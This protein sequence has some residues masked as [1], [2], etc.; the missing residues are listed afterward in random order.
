[1]KKHSNPDS[2]SGTSYFGHHFLATTAS[3]RA[4]FGEPHYAEGDYTID[5]W[6]LD[7]GGGATA[8]VYHRGETR[9]HEDQPIRWHVGAHK[10]ADA[11]AATL[12]IRELL[13]PTT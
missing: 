1:M 8:T 7:I 2:S 10:S 9:Y 5:E 3:L 11:L 13:T 6:V 12:Q 4:L